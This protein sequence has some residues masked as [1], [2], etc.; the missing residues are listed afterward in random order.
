MARVDAAIEA[1]GELVTIV[2]GPDGVATAAAL[3]QDLGDRDVEVARFVAAEPLADCLV[4][5]GVE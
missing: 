2:A 1:G 3:A 5:V 4:V